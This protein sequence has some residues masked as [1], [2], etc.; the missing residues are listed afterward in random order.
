MKSK[1]IA[2]FIPSLERGGVERTLVN[3]LKAFVTQGYCVDLLFAYAR[4]E[5]LKQVPETV[6]IISLRS[7]R[8][9]P[10]L[11]GLVPPR[12]SI[13]LTTLPKLSAYLRQAQPEVLISFQSSVVAVWAQKLARSTTRLIVRESN[14]PSKAIAEDKRLLAKLVPLLKR[15]S[16]PRADVIVANS[17]GAAQDLARIL[18]LPVQKIHIIY[19]PTY[20]DSILEKSQEPLNH[21]WF[22]P[23]EPPV[24]LGVGRLTHQKDFATLI[25]AFAIVRKELECRLVILGEGEER[26]KLEA[27]AKELGIG[28][29]VDLPGFVD[30]P[31]KY[32]AR[33]SL[34]V[35][36]S[37]YEGLPNVLIEALACG[38]PVVSTDCPSGPREILMNGKGGLLVPVGNA[39]KM[40]TAILKLLR[41]KSFAQSLLQFAREHLDRFKP[42]TCVS[43]YIMLV[44][45]KRL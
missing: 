30:N 45:G 18:H 17:K 36:S 38:T 20:D 4:D 7:A 6:R 29:D 13:S 15:L 35:L 10:S 41:D 12:V 28:E 27:L 9:M 33:A 14:T 43:K 34:F 1:R 26:P 8:R 39:E 23:G 31:Y 11:K 19:N 22:Q 25:R 42:E 44:E 21:P 2:F 24:I 32:M 37:R 16:Y 5:F 3:L 40:A